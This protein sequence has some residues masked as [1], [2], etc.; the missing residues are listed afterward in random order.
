MVSLESAWGS[1][2][3]TKDLLAPLPRRCW[4]GYRF[5]GCCAMGFAVELSRL[6]CV[7][8]LHARGLFGRSC[9]NATVPQPVPS[10]TPANGWLRSALGQHSPDTMISIR[11]SC[12]LLAAPESFT[13]L[14]DGDQGPGVGSSWQGV[15]GIRAP[16]GGESTPSQESLR[17]L[18]HRFVDAIL[19]MPDAEDR[20]TVGTDPSAA[21]RARRGMR[22]GHSVHPCS[23]RHTGIP[24]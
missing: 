1:R 16:E 21:V 24:L 20:A 8:R 9:Q 4:A 6:V 23:L 22:V 13:R 18:L 10:W 12:G 17:W 7:L 15:A 19:K 5:V 2:V 14:A 3:S 11:S